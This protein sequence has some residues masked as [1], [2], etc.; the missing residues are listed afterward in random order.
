M[1]FFITVRSCPRWLWENPHSSTHR[2]GYC[3]W[4]VSSVQEV[5]RN[6]EYKYFGM[7]DAVKR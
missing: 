5:A 2:V 7:K 1:A 4:L 3:C 6:V